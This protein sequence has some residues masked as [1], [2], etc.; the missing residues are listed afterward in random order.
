MAFSVRLIS[1]LE[2]VCGAADIK[3]DVS[4][5]TLLRGER[6]AFQAVA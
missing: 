6:F 5:V 2:K 4:G 1:S 3:N